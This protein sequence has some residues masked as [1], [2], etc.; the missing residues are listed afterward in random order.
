MKKLLLPIASIFLSSVGFSQFEGEQPGSIYKI[1]KVRT[2]LFRYADYGL[3][4][5]ILTNYDKNGNV[6]TST[7]FDKNGEKKWL[8]TIFVYDSANKLAKILYCS[9]MNSDKLAGK[10]MP[11]S[12]LDSSKINTVF[13]KYDASGRLAKIVGTIGPDKTPTEI[14]FSYDP[15]IS[16]WKF[17]KLKDSLVTTLITVYE[18]PH[19][20]KSIFSSYDSGIVTENSWR[21][22]YKNIFDKSGKLL[23]RITE[24]PSEPSFCK[25]TFYEYN[26][27][28]LLIKRYTHYRG[29]QNDC[30]VRL[31]D[32]EYWDDCKIQSV[33]LDE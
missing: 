19:V 7:M 27:K 5:C 21:E 30:D 32:Y 2:M 24:L 23:K 8:E 31:Y 33:V 3:Q 1:N 4:N 20:A 11:D 12:L 14:T 10:E 28:G 18:S 22:T 15:L 29:L 6:L 9:Y 26:E 25:E 16:I 13:Y 17:H